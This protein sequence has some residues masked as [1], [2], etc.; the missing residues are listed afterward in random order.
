MAAKK[1]ETFTATEQAA[2][3]EKVRAILA[4]EDLSQTEAA[5]ES[6]IAY[7]TFTGWLA[8]TYQGN[9]D[10]IAGDVQIWLS[11]RADKAHAA[12][13]VPKAPEFQATP[14]AQAF[15]ETLRYAQVMPDIAVIAGGAGIGKTVA[16]QHYAASN[17][18]VWAATMEPCSAS[19]YTM[20]SE[21]AE[22]MNVAEKV[23]TKLSRAI[24]RRV[25]GAGG[26]IVV[27]EAQHLDARALEQL[28]ALH[29]RYGVGVALVGNETV[30]ARLEGE[31]R[32]AS[33]AQLFSRI[34]M[35]ITQSKPRAADMC[36][37][38][39]AWGV[40][41]AEEI[42]LLKAIARKPGALRVMTKCLRLA[43]M[44]AAGAEE[45]LGV[46]HIKAA[47]ERLSSQPVAEA[48]S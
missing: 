3:R 18:N 24:G 23:Q 11:A 41:G 28:R 2:I 36:A 7:G 10:R 9:N 43:S 13:K 1:N 17:P 46:K 47:W 33:F 6:G 40:T 25:E 38:I 48:A 29:D 32:K 30:Y 14:S 16:L 39:A 19:L 22:V 20:L 26:L 5:R 21:L 15:I 42:R 31:G 8:G 45:P 35:R 4:D 34:G 37:L 44:I 27:D 12:R